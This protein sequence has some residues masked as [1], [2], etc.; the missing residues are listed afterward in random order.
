MKSPFCETNAFKLS[1]MVLTTQSTIEFLTRSNKQS[2]T[3]V[4][5][6][7]F[8]LQGVMRSCHASPFRTM[9][10]LLSRPLVQILLAT[11]GNHRTTN[12]LTPNLAADPLLNDDLYGSWMCKWMVSAQQEGKA[13]RSVS[14][15]LWWFTV[16]S[17]TFHGII[18]MELLQVKMDDIKYR[19]LSLVF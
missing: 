2:L 12:G 5:F 4:L 3:Q 7:L 1:H 8:M 17:Q 19:L 10:M 15:M 11:S 13:R 18:I 16:Q 9:N 14:I 6:T